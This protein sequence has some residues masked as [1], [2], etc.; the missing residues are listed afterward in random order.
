VSAF[1][2]RDDELNVRDDELASSEVAVVARECLGKSHAR[3]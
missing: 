1:A 3:A 2:P